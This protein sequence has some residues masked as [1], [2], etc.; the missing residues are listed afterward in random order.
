MSALAADFRER[1]LDGS[2]HGD[3]TSTGASPRGSALP[4]PG[5]IRAQGEDH[6][7]VAERMDLIAQKKNGRSPEPRPLANITAEAP[8]A[9]K[10]ATM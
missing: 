10:L 5:A 1:L 9:P 8:S 7:N 4:S 6:G 3:L 2:N